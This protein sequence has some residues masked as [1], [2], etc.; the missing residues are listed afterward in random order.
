[1]TEFILFVQKIESEA[2]SLKAAVAAQETAEK[3][4]ADLQAANA[5]LTEQLASKDAELKVQVEN[6]KVI[7]YSQVAYKNF[8]VLYCTCI[9]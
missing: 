8:V 2:A 4:A 7:W 5:A 1:M 6:M 9:L 3:S